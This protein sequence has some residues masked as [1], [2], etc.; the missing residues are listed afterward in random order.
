MF[1]HS[2][3]LIC[4]CR[5]KF[6]TVEAAGNHIQDEARED[7]P[8]SVEN[9]VA[10]GQPQ[11]PRYDDMGYYDMAY[12]YPPPHVHRDHGVADYAGV[13]QDDPTEAQVNPPAHVRTALSLPYANI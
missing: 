7:M 5:F 8:R 3:G 2:R 4:V 13:A 12:N 9:I 11:D 6:P 10:R 1:S